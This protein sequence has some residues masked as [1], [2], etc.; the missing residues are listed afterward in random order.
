MSCRSRACVREPWSSIRS[1]V[2]TLALLFNSNSSLASSH[3]PPFLFLFPLC[4]FL[5][6]VSNPASMILACFT[7]QALRCTAPTVLYCPSHSLVARLVQRPRPGVRI[8]PRSE[9]G[10][11]STCDRTCYQQRTQQGR[12]LLY[13]SNVYATRTEGKKGGVGHAH[14]K[15]KK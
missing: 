12:C 3:R 1:R 10:V 2:F 9:G 5:C 15:K 13:A 7:A 4:F 6:P 8:F 14:G 11:T